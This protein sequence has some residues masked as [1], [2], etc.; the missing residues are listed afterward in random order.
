MVASA[1]GQGIGIHRGSDRLKVCIGFTGLLNGRDI[2]T[3]SFTDF[4]YVKMGRGALTS[5]PT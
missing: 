4:F 1:E 5:S 3:D 2:Q